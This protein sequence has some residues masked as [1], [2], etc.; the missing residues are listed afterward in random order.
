[1]N[2]LFFLTVSIIV[3]KYFFDISYINN[4]YKW[5]KIFAVLILLFLLYK[6]Y[7]N[8]ELKNS[9]IKS[10]DKVDKVPIDNTFREITSYFNENKNMNTVSSNKTPKVKRNVTNGQKKY[11]ASIQKWRCGHCKKLLD[12]SYEVDHILALYKGG[13]NDLDNL[14]ALCRNCPC[15]QCLR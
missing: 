13:T 8:E 10:I 11:V 9:I 1:M 4:I 12:A 3:L 15:A 7:N 5:L 2:L 14:V 6:Y